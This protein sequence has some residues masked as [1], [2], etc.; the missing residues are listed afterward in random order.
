MTGFTFTHRSETA[1]DLADMLITA[2]AC[3]PQDQAIRIPLL[4]M[5]ARHLGRAIQDAIAL[6]ERH[7]AVL[8][9][10]EAMQAT[11]RRADISARAALERAEAQ[12]VRAVRWFCG[13]AALFALV[14][15]VAVAGWPA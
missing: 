11:A 7:V 12:L 4:P 10:A 5:Q 6:H 15:A 3:G 2:S 14:L 8:A 13:A 9:Q 1:S